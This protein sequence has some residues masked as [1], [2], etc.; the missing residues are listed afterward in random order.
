LI[1]KAS[2][3]PLWSASSETPPPEGEVLKFTQRVPALPDDAERWRV[4]T[5]ASA[6]TR[7]SHFDSLETESVLIPMIGAD[8]HARVHAVRVQPGRLRDG[9]HVL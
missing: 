8:R 9:L 1:W 4:I 5:A 6:A 3:R 7:L 2:S